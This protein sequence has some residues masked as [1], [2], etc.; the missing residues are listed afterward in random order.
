M[1]YQMHCGLLSMAVPGVVCYEHGMPVRTVACTS[2]QRA[3]ACALP[4][5]CPYFWFQTM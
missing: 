5:A 3:H 4:S 1:V 2:V